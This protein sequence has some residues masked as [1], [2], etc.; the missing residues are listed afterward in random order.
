MLA[1]LLDLFEKVLLL[2]F[3]VDVE[4]H[5]ALA[6]GGEGLDVRREGDAG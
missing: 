5:E 6:C 3:V 4:F 1:G 2:L